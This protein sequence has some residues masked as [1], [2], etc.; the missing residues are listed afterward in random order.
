MVKKISA[1]CLILAVVVS[2]FAFSSAAIDSLVSAADE[3][4][5][6]YDASQNL[7]IGAFENLESIY[8]KVKFPKNDASEMKLVVAK[9]D[10][11]GVLLSATSSVLQKGATECTT[12]N[13]ATEGLK[14]V[15]IFVWETSLKPAILPGV[16]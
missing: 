7:R 1:L 12:E 13:I 11:Y 3:G 5:K 10:E 16:I 15:K 6:F 4:V 2:V 8:A 14:T 9:Y